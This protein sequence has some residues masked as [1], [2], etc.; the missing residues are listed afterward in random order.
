MNTDPART[1]APFIVDVET[2][3][4]RRLRVV[5]EQAWRIADACLGI[6]FLMIV[7]IFVLLAIV[8]ETVI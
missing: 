6:L 1:A 4:E 5:R 8:P 2:E 3:E 7:F